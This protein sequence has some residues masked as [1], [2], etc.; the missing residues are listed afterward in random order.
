MISFGSSAKTQNFSSIKNHSDWL[1]GESKRPVVAGIRPESFQL[2]ESAT[3]GNSISATIQVIEPLGSTMDVYLETA[4]GKRLVCRVPARPLQESQAI[5]AQVSP[6][7]DSPLRAKRT[8][9]PPLADALWTQPQ[10]PASS[11]DLVITLNI[12][13]PSIKIATKR[14]RSL[15]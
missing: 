5:V 8:G 11:N 12:G 10:G 13:L 9:R 15:R 7:R 3:E 14:R 2:S 1:A 4:S 6:P